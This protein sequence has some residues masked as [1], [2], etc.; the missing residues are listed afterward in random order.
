[1]RCD[2]EASKREIKEKERLL[3]SHLPFP[4]ISLSH[5]SL[6]QIISDDMEKT[7]DGERKR[8]MGKG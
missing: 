6:L 5:V 7:K 2:R 3:T 1:M 8:E 4:F